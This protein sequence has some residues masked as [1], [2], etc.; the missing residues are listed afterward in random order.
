MTLGMIGTRRSVWIDPEATVAAASRLMREQN[1]GELVV[2]EPVGHGRR[3]VGVP[4]GIISAR[5]IVTRVLA[6]ELDPTVITAGDILWSRTG[7]VSIITDSAADVVL[8]IWAAD[9]EAAPVLHTDGRL[10]G[11]IYLDELLRAIAG[12]EPS[13]PHRIHR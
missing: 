12:S 1:V 7:T 11:V 2:A 4:S 9:G 6:R 10:A 3:A 13:G 8:R 5:D